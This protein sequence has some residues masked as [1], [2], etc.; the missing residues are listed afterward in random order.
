MDQSGRGSGARGFG[1]ASDADDG[2]SS[3]YTRRE[4]GEKEL[5]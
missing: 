4:L 3:D 5:S 2:H 1:A